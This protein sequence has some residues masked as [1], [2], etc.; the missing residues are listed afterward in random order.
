[1]GLLAVAEVV[2]YIVYLVRFVDAGGRSEYSIANQYSIVYTVW[3]IVFL[4]CSLEVFGWVV[5]CV[6]PRSA[7]SQFNTTKVPISLPS[8]LY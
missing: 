2:V 7:P 4:L 8:N 5:F 1:M 3:A 6:M